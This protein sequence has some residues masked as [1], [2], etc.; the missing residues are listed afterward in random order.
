MNDTVKK[1]KVALVYADNYG[2]DYVKERVLRAIDL[3]GGIERFVSKNEKVLLKPNLL[4]KAPAEK[5]CTTHPSVFSA[6]GSILL[7]AGY[8]NIKYGDSSGGHSRTE[9]V[10]LACGVA[11]AAEALGIEMADFTVGIETKYEGRCADSFIL[12]P[13]VLEADAIINICKMKTHMLERITGGMKN[14]FGAVY[15]LN[16]GAAHVKFPNADEFAKMMSDLNNMIPP[17][18]HIMDGIVA[19]E[20][21]GP[22]SGDPTPMNVILASD[23]PVALDSVFCAL[24]YLDPSLVPTNVRGKEYGCGEYMWENIEVVCE[25]KTISVAEAQRKYGKADFDVY[26]G[27]EKNENIKHLKFLTPLLKKKLKADSSLCVGCG[28]CVKSCPV[29]GKAIRMKKRSGKSVPYYDHK[30][31]IKCYCCQEMCPQK[32]ISLSTPL[33]EKLADR[34]WRFGFR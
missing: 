2:S 29:E 27:E 8:K 12:C 26:R 10:A 25:D 3:L 19:M 32:A 4:A 16:K 34:N 33:A 15:G 18:L 7:D 31:C 13:G 22:Q 11:D 20:G 17:R 9:P 30:K 1:S 24:V 21:N 23:D 5:A 14:L 6:V 28:I